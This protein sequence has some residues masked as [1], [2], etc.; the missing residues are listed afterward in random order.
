[1]T[2]NRVRPFCWGLILG[3]VVWLVVF[4]DLSDVPKVKLAS[5]YVCGKLDGALELQ[6]QKPSV[7]CIDQRGAY[8]EWI[9]RQ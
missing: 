7:E 5:A 9:A 3:N 8:E 4:W 2:A 1:M 6:K